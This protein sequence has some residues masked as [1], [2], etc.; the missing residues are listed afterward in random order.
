MSLNSSVTVPLGGSAMAPVSRSPGPLPL[1]A[2]MAAHRPP[3]ERIPAPERISPALAVAAPEL[4]V[5]AN[6]T[7]RTHPH[8]AELEPQRQVEPHDRLRL[9]EDGI[10][11]LRLVV[12]VDYPPGRR[13][14]LAH[15][16]AKLLVSWLAPVRPVV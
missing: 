13:H 7:A 1:V 5:V 10:A 9:R 4:D 12:A 6:P 14:R 15:A 2:E 16:R 11:E 3:E 8:P